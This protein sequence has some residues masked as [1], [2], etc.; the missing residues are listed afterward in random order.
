MNSTITLLT[1]TYKQFKNKTMLED[2]II[3][4]SIMRGKREP[5]DIDVLVLF[6]ENIDKGIE[7]E[8]RDANQ[9]N[10]V[11]I[12]SKTNKELQE[13][14][15]AARDGVFF[16]GFSTFNEEYLTK[17]KGFVAKGLFKYNASHLSPSKRVQISY[18]LH[19]RNHTGILEDTNSS[20]ISKDTILTPL[21]Q[22]EH[23]KEFFD[24]WNI[25]YTYIPILL[26]SRMSDKA[27]INTLFK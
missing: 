12:I 13:P 26:P 7:K 10:K 19:G 3:F 27:I 18:A 20:K 22:I 25:E 23:M 2:I 11:N 21:N 8:I 16:E 5:K 6:K 17:N 24:F 1:K 15:F 14:S 4:G 9:N